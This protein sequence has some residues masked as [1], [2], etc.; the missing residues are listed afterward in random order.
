MDLSQLEDEKARR[1]V[2]IQTIFDQLDVLW[3]R[4]GISDEDIDEFV[5]LNRGSTLQTIRAY[6]NELEHMQQV[7]R[8]KMSVFIKSAREEIEKLWED[9][10]YGDVEREAFTAFHGGEHELVRYVYNID[11]GADEHTEDLLVI[12]EEQIAKLKE[13]RKSKATTLV[14]IRKYFQILEEQKELEVSTD[15]PSNHTLLI[16]LLG[17]CK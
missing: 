17:F 4:L 8:E 10:I 11:H 12:H 1:E 3:K 9:L 15:P 16:W 6:E 7:K 14:A 5:E 2:H 13:E